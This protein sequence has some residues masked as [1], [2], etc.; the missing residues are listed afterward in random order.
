MSRTDDWCLSPGT[1]KRINDSGEVLYCIDLEEDDSIKE[2]DCKTLNYC[3]QVDFEN[4]VTKILEQGY[5]MSSSSCNS[6]TDWKAIMV[7]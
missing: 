5:T 3:N 2:H 6:R 4:E 1:Y 7:K